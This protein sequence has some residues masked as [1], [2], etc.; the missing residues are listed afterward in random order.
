MK[1]Q[2]RQGVFETNSSSMHSLVVK[3]IDE[4]YTEEEIRHSVWLDNNNVWSIWRQE[5]LDFGR[6]P[7]KF[8]TTF[9]EKVKYAI[10]SL[11]AYRNNKEVILSEIENIIREIIPEF[12]H[13]ELPIARWVDIEDEE[14]EYEAD[15]YGYID[16]DILT[17]FLEVENIDLK[18]FL[19][20]KKYIVVVD[21]DEFCI[22]KDMKDIGLI[23]K[24]MI[25]KEYPDY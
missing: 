20:N 21:G 19:T 16:D 17:R 4:Y 18:E 13:I 1:R 9:G 23:N 12:K 2:I 6:F 15:Y 24:E 14:T 11:C 8:L 7:F 22:W 25:E 3:K 5:S 10:V